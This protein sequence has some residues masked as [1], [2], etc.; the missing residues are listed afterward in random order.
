MN[1]K[2]LDGNKRGLKEEDFQLTSMTLNLNC[3]EKTCNPMD[4]LSVD[5]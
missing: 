2:T 5:P 4:R 3:S 1:L